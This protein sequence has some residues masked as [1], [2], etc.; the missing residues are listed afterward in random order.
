M[1]PT[2]LP[3]VGS[4]T[5]GSPRSTSPLSAT[6]GSRG[7]CGGAASRGGSSWLTPA[8][9]RQAPARLDS[10]TRASVYSG[11]LL[12]RPLHPLTTDPT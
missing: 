12:A 7:S 8:A 6:D 11:L 2:A 10:P 3:V 9:R 4:M 1:I 5:I